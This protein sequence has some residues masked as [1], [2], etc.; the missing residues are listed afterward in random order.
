[1]ISIL[2]FVSLVVIFPLNNLL[3]NIKKFIFLIIIFYV[4]KVYFGEISNIN[5][6]LK[7][8]WNIINIYFFTF[9]ILSIFYIWLRTLN[10]SISN[11]KNKNELYIERE[12]D[13][14]FIYKFL[15][16]ESEFNVLGINENFG[17]GKTFLINK[18][19]EDLDSNEYEVINVKCLLLDDKEIYP[20]IIK[21]LNRVLIKNL[22][23]MGHF[24]KLKN[25]FFRFMDNKYLGFIFNLF[26]R[27]TSID[28]IENFKQAIFKLNKN[29]VLIFDDFDRNSNCEKINKLFSFIDDFSEN[30]IKS[31]VLYNSNNLKSINEMYSRHYV[32]KYIP[33]TKNLT[34]LSFKR[35]IDKEIINLD[36]SEFNFLIS[37]F[38][39]KINYEK[40]MEDFRFLIDFENITSKKIMA[41]INWTP[42]NIKNF[43][44]EVKIY[45]N[46]NNLKI[47]K[48][49][50]ISYIFLKNVLYEEF[51]EKIDDNFCFEEKFP[52]NLILIK[53]NI[54]IIL[55]DLDV[56]TRLILQKEEILSNKNLEFLNVGNKRIF[57]S[58]NFS[59]EP[60]HI[61]NYLIKLNLPK[62]KIYDKDDLKECFNNIEKTIMNKKIKIDDTIANINNV[63]IY[64]LFNYFLIYNNDENKT[65]ENN[66]KIIN[67]IKKLKFL[68][69]SEYLSSYRRYYE[70]LIKCLDEN[71]NDNQLKSY[72]KLID[73]YYYSDGSFENV[74][75]IGE[76]FEKKSI[77][78]LDVFDDEKNKEKFLDLIYYKNGN[79]INDDYLDSFISVKFSNFKISDFIIDNFLSRNFEIYYKN[80]LNEIRKNI[81]KIIIREYFYNLN[82]YKE[83]T[84]IDFYNKYK[85][86]LEEILKK[87]NNYCNSIVNESEVIRKNIEKIINFLNI[88]IELENDSNIKEKIYIQTYFKPYI[89]TEIESLKGLTDEEKIKKIEDIYIKEGKK[90]EWVQQ[91]YE[92]IKK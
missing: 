76:S 66:E 20:Y 86:I 38:E 19:L 55:E 57:F 21:Q 35:L 52:I 72:E 63:I 65:I 85:E 31:L 7:N 41:Y 83:Y 69:K 44:N 14:E 90:L 88:L 74:F 22:I 1:M 60:M 39:R 48:R 50:I 79:K 36:K 80:I 6:I 5:D 12:L 53:D 67:A 78:I 64:V 17:E 11:I 71:N 70:K 47:E 59:N 62:L 26:I 16:N 13:K 24:E 32:E 58:K 56:L 91:I 30:N 87:G 68:G 23:F 10:E 3:K 73:E 77:L 34:K 28:D 51:Y 9:I 75:Y 84:N 18:V 54:N 4:F 45:L 89:P 49:I 46:D 61:N 33:V 81:N 29:I 8:I 82:K 2:Y 40:N 27:E 92:E 37:I 15:T 42:R 25:S 43:L